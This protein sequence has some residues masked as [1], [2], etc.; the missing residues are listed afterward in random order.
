[1]RNGGQTNNRIQTMFEAGSR[2]GQ[3]ENG[4]WTNIDYWM[5][6][7]NGGKVDTVA[8]IYLSDGTDKTVLLASETLRDTWQK[9]HAGLEVTLNADGALYARWQRP[10]YRPPASA[11]RFSPRRDYHHRNLS[12]LL[13]AGTNAVHGRHSSVYRGTGHP[14][15]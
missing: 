8:A 1:M 13:R 11:A 15:R 3:L 5:K 12:D 10:G 7:D 9:F 4:K 2:P 6:G 14:G